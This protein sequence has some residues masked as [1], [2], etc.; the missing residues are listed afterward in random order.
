M[1]VG[2]DA[3]KYCEGL[4]SVELPWCSSVGDGAFAGC[5]ALTS[6]D[7]TLCTTIGFEAFRDCT[8][9]AHIKI[10]SDVA[11]IGTFAFSNCAGLNRIDVY[12]NTPLRI[13]AYV[14]KKVDEQKCTL[15][16]PKGTYLDYRNAVGWGEFE[17]I[18]ER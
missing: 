7:L 16:V 18:I 17:N 15:Y 5:V 4:T 6:V 10:P 2:I 3:F 13:D 1:D 9:L 8:S 12:W 11:Y 14:F